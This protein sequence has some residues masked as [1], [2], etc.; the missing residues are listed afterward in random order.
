MQVNLVNFE[1]TT[2]CTAS[3][4]VCT[5]ALIN[6]DPHFSNRLFE[7]TTLSFLILLQTWGSCSQKAGDKTCIYCYDPDT[8]QQPNL[9]KPVLSTSN[10]SMPSQ[11]KCLQHVGDLFGDNNI[12]LQQSIPSLLPSFVPRAQI[13]LKYMVEEPGVIYTLWWSVC[14]N[15]MSEQ[16]FVATRNT[17]AVLHPPY[18]L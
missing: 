3:Q 12:A 10:N 14:T 13:C 4:K 18:S 5:P 11:G 17:A 16:Q 15:A 8:K 7:E 6:S 9:E 1:A 2:L